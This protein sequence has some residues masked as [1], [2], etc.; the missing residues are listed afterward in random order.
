MA[1]K[2]VKT[3]HV[4]RISCDGAPGPG[5][6]W[7]IVIECRSLQRG[8]SVWVYED[9]VMTDRPKW[10]RVEAWTG[11]LTWRSAYRALAGNPELRVFGDFWFDTVIEGVSEWAADILRLVFIVDEE[12]PHDYRCLG[13][14]LLG[15]TDNEITS[16]VPSSG[17]NP[18]QQRE[19]INDED[20]TEFENLA[21]LARGASNAG[22][23]GRSL[24]EIR[25]ELNVGPDSTLDDMNSVIAER[26]V[27]IKHS[28]EQRRIAEFIANVRS[29][30]GMS[31]EEFTPHRAAIGSRLADW[32][33]LSQGPRPDELSKHIELISCWLAEPEKPRGGYS[34]IGIRDGSEWP[35]LMWILDAKGDLLPSILSELQ[36]ERPQEAS[37]L[38]DEI[39]RR[40]K[41]QTHHFESPS[42][43]SG[44]PASVIGCNIHAAHVRF[45]LRFQAAC[46]SL[47]IPIDD[48][49][50]IGDLPYL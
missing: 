16:I 1:K 40:G 17:L 11:P 24:Q 15:F 9:N 8:F 31:T 28:F 7:R 25:F 19:A 29:R 41:S 5:L 23:I 38:S 14:L 21:N 48:E 3:K 18:F 10:R 50:R 39:M 22:L 37:V 32:E 49:Y 42:R 30:L 43:S 33:E 44:Y 13:D 35:V 6:S 12:S 46:D 47:K 27:E 26:V 2:S 20:E 45:A 4:I 36:R 34:V